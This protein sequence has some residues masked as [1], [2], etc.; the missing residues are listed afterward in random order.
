MRRINNVLNSYKTDIT[1][2]RNCNNSR[3]FIVALIN[4]FGNGF[5]QI[6][7]EK[8]VSNKRHTTCSSKFFKK[9]TT[10]S[11]KHHV[12]DKETPYA[13]TK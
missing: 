12:M 6:S 2:S 9:F 10:F 13:Y 3:V 7:R 8:L 11:E 5:R 4:E 1:N